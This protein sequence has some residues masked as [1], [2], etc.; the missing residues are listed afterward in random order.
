MIFL[1]LYLNFFQGIRKWL[2]KNINNIL[3]YSLGIIMYSFLIIPYLKEGLSYDY[4]PNGVLIFFI[5]VYSMVLLVRLTIQHENKHYY[6]S[7]PTY[8]YD[9][10]IKKEPP[11][12][13]IYHNKEYYQKLTNGGITDKEV[14]KRKE[15]IRKKIFN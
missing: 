2:K 9:K 4:Q 15:N 11:P 3:F 5:V 1:F 8:P 14:K 7:G 10:T 13:N 12:I 6:D